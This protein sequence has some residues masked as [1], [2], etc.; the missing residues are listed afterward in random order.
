MCQ[1]WFDSSSLLVDRSHVLWRI[2]LKFAHQIR[3]LQIQVYMSGGLYP[4]V[5]KPV[6]GTGLW[7]KK[8][9]NGDDLSFEGFPDVYR[10]TNGPKEKSRGTAKGR[11]RVINIG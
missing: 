3:D 11:R 2:T 4:S 6:N 5:P 1:I 7:G 8:N 9:A 10:S